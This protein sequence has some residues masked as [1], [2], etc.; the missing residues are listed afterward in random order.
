A[1]R[2]GQ[3]RLQPLLILLQNFLFAGE[4]IVVTHTTAGLDHLRRRQIVERHQCARRKD[5]DTA[6]R[7]ADYHAAD[8]K[9]SGTDLDAVADLDIQQRQQPRIEP[10]LAARRALW[11]RYPLAES[12]LRHLQFAAQRIQRGGSLYRCK[13]SD[14]AG[15][16]HRLKGNRL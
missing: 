12:L 16:Q 9:E 15:Y 13:L 6:V 1:L 5:I 14:L 2:R 4:Q 7:L 3:F 8:T 11:H 10:Y